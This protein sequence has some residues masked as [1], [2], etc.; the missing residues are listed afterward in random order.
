MWEQSFWIIWQR[1]WADEIGTDV[2]GG[3]WAGSAECLRLLEQLGT[4]GLPRHEVRN[5]HR[6][7]TVDGASRGV[8]GWGCGEKPG[9]GEE[10]TEICLPYFREGRCLTEC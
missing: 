2:V 10:C 7:S 6:G 1:F 3:W 9:S 5:H 4:L 8:W